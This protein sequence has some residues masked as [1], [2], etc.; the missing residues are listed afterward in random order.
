MRIG[1]KVY[2]NLFNRLKN[3]FEELIQFLVKRGYKEDM[4]IQ[5]LKE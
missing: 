3:Q 1:C 2:N 5:K 4:L